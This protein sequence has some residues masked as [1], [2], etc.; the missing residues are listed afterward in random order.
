MNTEPFPRSRASGADMVRPLGPHERLLYLYSQQHPRHFCVTA[1]LTG[2]IELQA[3]EPALRQ[4][5]A[6]HP[7]LSL[8][9]QDAD[10]GPYFA[11]ETRPIPSRIVM[12]ASS[13]C[14]QQL[15]E[16][17]LRT[18]FPTSHGP[19]ARLTLLADRQAGGRCMAI[20]TFHHAMGDALSAVAVLNDLVHCLNGRNLPTLPHRPPVETMLAG[21]RQEI[22]GETGVPIS[23]A[24][25]SAVLRQIAQKPLWRDFATDR[26]RVDAIQFSTLESER[27]IN[28]CRRQAATVQGALCAALALISASL[29]RMETLTV[30]TP[31]SIRPQAKVDRSE[32]GLFL[33]IGTLTL[34]VS[35]E[36]GFWAM[37]RQFNSDL[38]R[39]RSDAGIATWLG[40]LEQVITP[41]ADSDMACG[42]IGALTYDAV[43]SNL[44]VL[45][46]GGKADDDVQISALWGPCVL[47]RLNNECVIG[48]A[49]L[50]GRLHLT[51][52]APAHVPAV[53]DRIQSVVLAACE[54]P[55]EISGHA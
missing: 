20:L 27:L 1:E 51:Q 45:D 42:L 55:V 49:T 23:E 54:A 25:S 36:T 53:I 16:E 35:A 41:T 46:T 43:V 8:S 17:E 19:L 37:A 11:R 28:A 39:A 32:I 7:A 24:P 14:W 22:V 34:P 13:V 2:R 47:G 12:D 29:R 26:P 33:A 9:I 3:F 10:T 48:A 15:V 4:L 30:V 31:M 40:R 21:L 50:H 6:R 44:G 18:D 5:Q 38:A 52:T